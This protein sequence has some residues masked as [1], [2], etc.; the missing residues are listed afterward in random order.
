MIIAEAANPYAEVT[1]LIGRLPELLANAATSRGL[2]LKAQAAEIGIGSDTLVNFE[3]G[4]NY[5][6]A[7]LLLVL[8]WLGAQA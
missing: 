8:A 2:T 1:S 5:T 6:K 7:T 3:A 4:S